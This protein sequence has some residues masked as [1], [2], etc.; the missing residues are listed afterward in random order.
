MTSYQTIVTRVSL[1]VPLLCLCSGVFIAG[2]SGAD[3]SIDAYL[4]DT[5]TLHGISYTGDQV[6]LFLTGPNLPLN[7]VTLTDISR[8]A[9]QGYFTI[10]DLDNNQQWIL[11]WSTAHLGIDPGTYTVYVE[12]EPND[13]AHLGSSN[14][15][16]TLSVY[17]EDSGLSKV[18]ISD[19][20]SYTLNPEAHTSTLTESPTPVATLTTSISVTVP[21]SL[22]STS[23]VPTSARAAID[24][25]LSIFGVIGCIS[26]FLYWRFYH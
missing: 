3:S 13:K 19:G 2:V 1:L 6:Y 23:P 12:T 17:L 22:N 9:D 14:S 16:Q 8:R 18:S 15:Y 25:S 10:V 4:G 5:I 26:L 21:V 20:T 11:R 7:G 24:P